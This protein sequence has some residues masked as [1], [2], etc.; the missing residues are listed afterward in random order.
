MT[1]TF[2]KI[3]ENNLY[4]TFKGYR[5]ISALRND[6]QNLVAFSTIVHILKQHKQKLSLAI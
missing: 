4:K 3:S 5:N 2:L 6:G 1:K